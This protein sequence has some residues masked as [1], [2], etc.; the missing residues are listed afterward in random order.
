MKICIWS[1]SFQADTLA[2]A[3][4]LDRDPEVNLLIV[5]A[6]PD[7]YRSEPIAKAL[8]FSCPMLDRMGN[9]TEKLVHDF[10]ADLFIADN[11]LPKYLVGK[12]MVF[13]W[14]GLPL[15]IQPKR[16]IKAFHRYC[17]RLIGDITKPNER[18]LA[19]CYHQMDYEHR[20]NHWNIASD[21]CR[22]WGSAYSDLLL[23]PPYQREYLGDYYGLDVLNRKNIIIS[24]TWNYGSNVFGVLGEDDEVFKK[25]LSTANKF[26][27]N[28]IFSLHDRYRYSPELTD[29]IKS[30]ADSYSRSFIK[31]KN[32][33]SDNLADLVISD[34][35][36]CNF[37]SFIV[38]HYFMNKPS[39]HVKPVDTDKLFLSLPTR[40][41]GKLRNMF[42]INNDRLWLYSFD[43]NGGVMPADG[44]ELIEDLKQGLSDPSYGSISAM[45]FI[46]EKIYQPDGNTSKR[47]ISD[48]KN[49]LG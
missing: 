48:L 2:L 29:K 17:K 24:L 18:F 36:I 44:Q 8:P 20:I 46:S 47:I 1:T 38:W 32:E 40:K 12:K 27:A 31:F 41:H 42:R 14:H 49:W 37:S 28:L 16:D 21:N 35:M 9:G 33:H 10:N 34:V 15:K 19:Q 6:N 43:D 11:H 25:L 5:C 7:A 39:I 45:K 13:L 26:E 22:I 30:H 23:K 4:E 3:V